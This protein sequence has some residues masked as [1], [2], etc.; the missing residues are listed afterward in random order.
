MTIPP[1]LYA[2]LVAAMSEASRYMGTDGRIYT[3]TTAFTACENPSWTS[4]RT[5]FAP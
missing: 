3:F 5:N 4:F 1:P 2:A